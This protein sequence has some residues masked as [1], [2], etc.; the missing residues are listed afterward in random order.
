MRHFIIFIF[1]S[2]LFSSCNSNKPGQ[3]VWSDEFNYTGAPDSTKWNYET[4]NGCPDRCGWGNNEAQIY[5]KDLKNVRVENGSLIIDAFKNGTQW[6]SGRI[7][8]EAKMNFTYGRI[9]FRA[10][11]PTSLGSWSALWMLG[12]NY[13]TKGWPACGE[14]DV[15]EHVGRNPG[16]VQSVLHTPESYGNTVNLKS[17]NVNAIVSDFH[18]YQANWTS[19]R[20]EFSVD[21]ITFYTFEPTSIN[22]K[23]WPFDSPFYIIMNIAMGGNLGGPVIDPAITVARMEVDYVR[24]YQ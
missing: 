5:T 9:E 22:E 6:T 23:T 16:V 7:T 3:L 4:G 14:I 12:G 10:K 20:I 24:V 8:S 13:K 17:H 15:M 21:G 11:I 1:L 2:G 19:N 18:L